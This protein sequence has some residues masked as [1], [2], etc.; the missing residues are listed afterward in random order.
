MLKR[1]IR[2]VGPISR[3]DVFENMQTG[4]FVVLE[5]DL[6]SNPCRWRRISELGGHA[7]FIGQHGSKSMPAREC[8][9]S[10]EDCIY[11]ICDYPH[12]KYFSSP[13]RDSGVYNMRNER[14]TPLMSQTAAPAHDAGQWRPAWFFPPEAV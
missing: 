1:F 13:F 5:A 7:L 6:H 10:E 11:F 4:G 14:I 8:S 9:G 3:D 12:P 2:R